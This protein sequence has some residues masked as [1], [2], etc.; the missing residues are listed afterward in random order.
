MKELARLVLTLTVICVLSGLLLGWVHGLTEEPIN[1]ALREERLAAVWQVIPP[2]DN[3][4]DE[5][6]VT[7]TE[8]GREWTFYVGRKEGRFSGTAVES[9]SDKGYGGTITVMVGITADGH[10]QGI[11][12]LQQQETPGLGARIQEADFKDQFSG[13]SITE[14]RWAVRKDQG[15][16]DQITAATIS[17]RAVVDAVQRGI[18]VYQEHKAEIQQ[19]MRQSESQP[20]SSS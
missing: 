16:V 4:P 13:K 2:F 11:Q 8:D 17:S 15:D 9:F 1:A 3:S 5:D 20:D 19:S 6:A 7:V 10:L 12:I 18:K 14:T